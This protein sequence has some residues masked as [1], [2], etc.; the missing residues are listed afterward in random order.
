MNICI[1]LTNVILITKRK[2]NIYQIFF[3]KKKNKNL[4][5][6]TPI[7]FLYVTIQRRLIHFRRNE[8]VDSLVCMSLSMCSSTTLLGTNEMKISKKK[9]IHRSVF[10]SSGSFNRNNVFMFQNTI[11][12]QIDW[13]NCKLYN[14]FRYWKERFF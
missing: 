9:I 10:T 13:F 11:M 2:K 4:L 7:S 3:F 12:I 14:I 8:A 6:T 1:A 5:D